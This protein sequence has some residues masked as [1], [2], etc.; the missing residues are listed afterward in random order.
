[1]EDALGWFA[2]SDHPGHFH[3][4]R[5]WKQLGVRVSLSPSAG[6]DVQFPGRR[7]Y[8]FKFLLKHYPIRSQAHGERKV[9]RERL[10]RWNAAERAL[11]WHA[12]YD[13][14]GAQGCFEHDQ[15]ELELFE[16]ASF[17]RR[18]LIE[19]LSGV[20]V[21]AHPP[22]W[23]TP[24]FWRYLSEEPKLIRST[25]LSVAAVGRS[26]SLVGLAKPGMLST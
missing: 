2:F 16:P 18:R 17:A 4:R 6:H 22:H 3:Q 13:E 1:V 5:A 7:V 15:A 24:P 19:R 26:D 10:P 12:Q 14:V 21:F 25:R 8:P 11:G 23:A 9:L 20:G